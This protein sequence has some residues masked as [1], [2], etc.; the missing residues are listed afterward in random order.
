MSELVYEVRS[1]FVSPALRERYLRWLREG[2]VQAVVQ[3]GAIDGEVRIEADGAV[4]SRYRFASAAAFAAYESG[5]AV[6]LRA[7]GRALFS[8]GV[9]MERAVAERVMGLSRAPLEVVPV[10]CLRDNYAYL[11]VDRDAREA[12]VVDP[13]EA[14]PVET[15]LAE[16]GLTL[17]QIWCTHHH[18]DHV[19]GNEALVHARADLAVLGSRYDA[20]AARIPAQTRGLADGDEVL[21]GARSFRAMAIPGHTLGA[22]AFVG[23]GLAFTGDTLFSG[24]C[25]RV[26]EG[27]MPMMHGSLRRLAG[28]P[29]DTRVFSGHEYTVRNL[30]FAAEVEPESA[31]IRARLEAVRR[32][33]EGE[34]PSVGAPLADE[35]A[36][37]P[38]LR[39]DEPAVRAFA[40]RR[41]EV[42]GPDEVFARLREA[43]DTF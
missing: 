1:R 7:E 30:E 4:V 38:F 25:G 19:G 32:L 10:A 12:V 6:A 26:F 13:S 3:G 41:G 5:P 24:G 9:F 27:T 36:T 35:L 14:A 31:A 23:E 43:K 34:R 20:E 33:R 21:F 28:L 40:A 39:A 18:F 29:A 2:H 8:E 17:R 22:L 42:K 11:L 37:N 15:A 16:L